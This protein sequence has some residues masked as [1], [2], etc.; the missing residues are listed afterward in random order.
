ME[1]TL[2]ELGAE[3]LEQHSPLDRLEA[4]GTLRIALKASGLDAKS[5]ALAQLR[6]VFEKVMPAELEK[7]G[8]ADAA[9]VCATVIEAVTDGWSASEAQVADEAVAVFQRLGS[10]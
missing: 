3:L 1:P 9:A 4:R 10:R 5:V 2:F 8:V 7:R 6:V